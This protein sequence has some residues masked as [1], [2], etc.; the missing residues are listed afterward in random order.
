MTREYRFATRCV[1]AGV[2]TDAFGAARPP[3][4]NTTTFAFASSADLQAAQAKPAT[5]PLYTRYGNNPTVMAVERQLA[6]I[7]GAE[8]ALVFS[9]G[10][11]AI[12]TACLALG[13]DGVACMGNAYGG[14]LELLSR[15]LPGLGITTRLVQPG[16]TAA[17]ESFLSG[18]HALVVAESPTNPDLSVQDIAALAQ[19]VHRHQGLLMLDNTFATPVNQRPLEHGADLV[20]HSATKYL[21]GHSDLTAGVAMGSARLMER[22]NEWRRQLG[23]APAPETAALLGRS[24]ATLE[25]R[26][27]RQNASALAIAQFLAA[28]QGVTRVCYPGLLDSPGHALACQQMDGFGGML[29]FEVDGDAETAAAVVDRLGLFL[30][31]PSLGGVESL[32]TQPALTSHAGLTPEER[33]QRGIPDSQIRLSIGLEDTADLIDDLEQA[34]AVQ[35]GG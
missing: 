5:T 20:V 15:Q 27:Q 6:A 21:G 8:R 28:H 33:R 23:Q 35:T 11:A 13:S 7:E 10:M 31:A 2:T 14:T 19:Q 17:L 32:A 16:D 34:L 25:V 1:H 3:I 22:L 9:A 24:L 4:Y 18:R 12:S 29:A 26:V 30:N